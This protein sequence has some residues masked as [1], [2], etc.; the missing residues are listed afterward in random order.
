MGAS[1]SVQSEPPKSEWSET[2]VYLSKTSNSRPNPVSGKP[3]N[4]SEGN[5]RREELQAPIR[6]DHCRKTGHAKDGCWFLYPYLRPIRGRGERRG[7]VVGR[8][9]GGIE[10]CVKKNSQD[11]LFWRKEREVLQSEKM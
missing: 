7:G 6:Y 1:T 8:K 9:K 5:R 11:V 4:P 3:T 10:R 2:S